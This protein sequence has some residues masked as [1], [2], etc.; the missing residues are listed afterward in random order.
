VVRHD[1]GTPVALRLIR[2]ALGLRLGQGPVSVP[3]HSYLC[4]TMQAVGLV[5]RVGL[6]DEPAVPVGGAVIR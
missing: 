1:V 6:V 3:L 5:A 2:R 4:S